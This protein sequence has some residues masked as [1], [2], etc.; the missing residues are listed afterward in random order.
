ME[1]EL[2]LKPKNGSTKDGKENGCSYVG[3]NTHQSGTKSFKEKILAQL[4]K[5]WEFWHIHSGRKTNATFSP[6]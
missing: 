6:G 5:N 4:L 1:I 3:H 2:A